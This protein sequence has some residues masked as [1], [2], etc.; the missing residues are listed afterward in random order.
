LFSNENLTVIES[1]AETL[2]RISGSFGGAEVVMDAN[3]LECVAKLLES[4]NEEVRRWTCDM[5]GEL[6]RHH[7]TAPAVWGINTCQP[8]VSLLR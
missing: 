6:A 3:A 7:T 5:L 2:C 1:V 4:P 8:L